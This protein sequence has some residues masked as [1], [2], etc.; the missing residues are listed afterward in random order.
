MK[1]KQLSTLELKQKVSSSA[2]SGM[3]QEVYKLLQEHSAKLLNDKDY[4]TKELYTG[5]VIE[6]DEQVYE[7]IVAVCN[8]FNKEKGGSVRAH[9]KMTEKTIKTRTDKKTKQKIAEIT[10]KKG[11]CVIMVVNKKVLTN[12]KYHHDFGNG[13]K[14]F[15]FGKYYRMM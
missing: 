5:A 9:C 7:K 10:G 14:V 12:T 1:V 3:G 15:H 4:E 6:G 2:L 8:H 13:N 11:E